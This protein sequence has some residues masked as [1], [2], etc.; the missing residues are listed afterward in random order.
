MRRL[1]LGLV[2][3]LLVCAPALAAPVALHV[4]R[5]TQVWFSEDHSV[6]MIAFVFSL[7][8]GSA[9]DPADKPGL[10]AFA[11]ALLDE[12]AAGLDSRAFHRALSDR[13][14]RLSVTPDRDALIVSLVT[15]SKDAPEALHLLSLALSRPRFD[16]GSL[17]R[18]RVQMTQKLRQEG[19]NPS[20]VARR[21]FLR[22][23][24]NGHVYGHAV[25]GDAAGLAAVT[26]ADLH[27][28]AHSHWVRG[29]MKIAVAGDIAPVTL[30]RLLKTALK[31]LPAAPPHPLPVVGKLGA[32][33]LH[34][35]AM[36]A[37]QPVV[38]FGLPGIMRND[39]D[40]LP[41]YIANYILGGGGF[42]SRLT[43][44]VRIKH[45]LTYNIATRILSFRRASVM[46]GEMALRADTLKP[47]LAAVRSTLAAFAADGPTDKELADAKTHLID[48]LPLT[49][50]S[51]VGTAAQLG[52]FQREGL[53]IGYISERNTLIQ[54]VTID[55]VRRAAKRLFTPTHLT[56][57]VAGAVKVRKTAPSASSKARPP[58][59]QL[60]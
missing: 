16:S 40:F 5:G 19:E 32:P 30:T 56:I 48:A 43:H 51:D 47:T 53:G 20:L 58:R 31:P 22:A 18:V 13:A 3:V 55:A 2:S 15:L 42:D 33:G 9:Y 39:P 4:D 37:P 27:N 7:P 35:A 11:G 1:L 26:S 57:L 41:G 46:M 60:H 23:F 36:P 52:V 6:P 17:T 10:A 54:A 38:V 21:A 49:F 12:G 45:G 44:Q 14:I 24:F 50:S 59:A 29:G 25:D 34:Y 8:A 28:F